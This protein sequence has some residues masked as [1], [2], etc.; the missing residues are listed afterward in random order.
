MKILI[1]MDPGILI[2]VKGYG[3]HERLVEMFAIEYSRLGH[4]VDL[5][6]TTGSVVPGCV[7]YDFGK[8][9]FPPKKKDAL[10]A[11][12]KA[13][14]FLWK[15]RHEYDLVHNFG[16]LIYLLPILNFRVKKIMTYGR[17]ITG[18]NIS[19]LLKLPHKNI[20]FTGCSSSLIGRSG[21][22]GTWF[23]VYN[24]INFNK[25]QVQQVV[26]ANAPLMFLGRIEKIKGLHTA[27]AVTKATNQKLV[28]AGNIS[29]LPEENAYFE[30][31]IKPHIN[32][33]QIIYVG[34]L[35]DTQKNDWLGE[36]KALLMPIEWNEPFGIV[37]IEAMAC[38]T[39][40]IAF[41]RGSVNE[42]ID[43]GIT[44]FK[45]NNVQ[46]M[47]EKVSKITNINRLACREQ[48]ERR[49]DVSVIA[50]KYLSLF[51]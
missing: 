13:W 45:V 17:E 51:S 6:I 48:A 11:I 25:Y 3:G 36:S 4:Q 49:F 27:I 34:E 19:R 20:V 38:G 12:P 44:G 37:M 50:Q 30:N 43:E 40:V 39:P 33:R 7:V 10:K 32:G 21:A 14:L 1:V 24:A 46:E 26:P 41:N 15:H 23:T 47:I 8:E 31:E 9:G 18:S 22:N 42:V 29:K 16:R 35:N 5:L 28:I 2:P